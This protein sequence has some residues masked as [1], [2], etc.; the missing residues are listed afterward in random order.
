MP[1]KTV[2]PKKVSPRYIQKP[3]RQNAKT[4]VTNYVLKGAK[5]LIKPLT[6][7]SDGSYSHMGNLNNFAYHT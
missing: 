6:S 4:R 1:K 5:N 2:N 7:H 3:R